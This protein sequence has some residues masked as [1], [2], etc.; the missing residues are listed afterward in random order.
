MW[1]YITTVCVLLIVI[2]L[3]MNSSEYFVAPMG[4]N[5]FN[6]EILREFVRNKK[7]QQEKYFHSI[8]YPQQ[9]MYY[10]NAPKSDGMYDLEDVSRMGLTGFLHADDEGSVDHNNNF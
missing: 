4:G 1:L 10:E 6:D 5:I 7:S 8:E 3:V 2:L 9:P